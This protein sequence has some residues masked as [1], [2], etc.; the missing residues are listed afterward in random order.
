MRTAGITY[1]PQIPPPDYAKIAERATKDARKALGLDLPSRYQG[2]MREDVRLDWSSQVVAQ[3]DAELAMYLAERDQAL[4][5]FWFYDPRK[6][7]PQTS[8]LS[9]TGVRNAVAKLVYGDKK[10]PLPVARSNEELARL[11]EE[12]GVQRVENAEAQLVEAAK[13][14]EAAH[15]RRAL[16][17]RQMQD[18]VLALSREPYKWSFDAIAKR[19][20]VER[21]LIYNMRTSA[22]NRQSS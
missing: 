3:A 15:T 10:H 21:T 7:L 12:L 9:L 14:V 4:A 1:G 20:G 18:T 17:V 5:H 2:A 6:R 19:A 13:I 16:A 22:L 8:G 11:G